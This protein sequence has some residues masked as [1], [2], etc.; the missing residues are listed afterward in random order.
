MPSEF[1][2]IR[3]YFT[4]PTSHT[5]VG[6]GDD[7]ALLQVGAGMELAVST[8]MLVS[9][10]HFFPDADPLQLGHKVLAVN[11]SDIAA[12]GA[13]PRWATLAAALPEADEPWIAAFARGL[14][15][16]AERYGVD[17][18]GGDTTRGPLNLCV[19]IIGEVPVGAALMRSGAHP[20]D[21][22]WVSGELGDAALALGHL[23]SRV[24]LDEQALLLCLARLNTPTPRVELGMALRGTATS[25]IDVSDG[26]LQDL[27]H[28]LEMSEVGAELRAADLPRSAATAN[29]MDRALADECVL[30]GG[31]DYELCFTAHPMHRSVIEA[32]IRRLGVRLTRI[33]KI[34]D[35]PGLRL[36]DQH[37]TEIPITKTGFDHF[38]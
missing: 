2:L 4:R 12:M 9:G 7:C 25:C 15:A 20:G 24:R 35:Q 6:V 36:L 21:D 31:D 32:L 3:K 11:L 27:G 33:G 13:M 26:L 8:D 16:V 18:I 28:I 30:S 1:E 38:A 22:V 5:R 29:C 34:V 14:F 37:G 10:T 23:R 17:L 19:Q